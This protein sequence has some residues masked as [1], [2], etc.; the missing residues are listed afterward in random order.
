MD[1][2]KGGLFATWSG[3]VFLVSLVLLLTLGLFGIGVLLSNTHG[4]SQ[5]AANAR[6]LHWTNATLGASGI[7]RASVAQAVFFTFREVSDDEASAIAIEEAQQNL[8]GVSLALTSP[9]ALQ[10]LVPAIEAFFSAGERVVELASSGDASTAEALRLSTVEPTFENLSDQLEERQDQLAL[11]INDSEDASGRKSR[12][13]FVGI[14]FMIPAVTMIIFWLVLRR[15]TREREAE[16]HARIEAERDLS[17][18]KDEF[19][20]GLSHEL[21]TPLTTIFGF[22]ELLLEDPSVDAEAHELLGLINSSSAD[23]SRMV[24]DLLTAARLDAEALTTSPQI[25]DL[26]EQVDAVTAPYLRAG[27]RLDVRVPSMEVYADPLHVRQIIQNLVSNA[28]RHGGDHVVLTASQEKGRTH[29]VAAD[30]GPGVPEEME[31]RLFKRFA[32]RGRQALIAGSVGLGLAISQELAIRMNGNLEYRRVDGWTSF[33]L[34][35]P[36][37][38]DVDLWEAEPQLVGTEVGE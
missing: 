15:R 10:E 34:R 7:A 13:T 26:A 35:F 17:R 1:E 38:P 24:D 25:V 9:D 16:M 36:T 30:D 4:A 8:S 31:E 21:R 12:V 18:A 19:I 6:Q 14:T 23:L 3:R 33:I 11:L 29:L 5:V 27:E 37:L 32:H 20:A 28:L 22:S 2:G